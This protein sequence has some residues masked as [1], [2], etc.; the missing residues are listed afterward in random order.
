MAGEHFQICGVQIT[1]NCICESKNLLVPH[2]W[3]N[4]PPGKTL[5]RQREIIYP[6]PTL[7]CLIVGGSNCKFLGKNQKSRQRFFKALFPALTKGGG[8]VK[9]P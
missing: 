8:I 4:S 2:S 9:V 5:L 3:Q 6:P 7:L 1:G